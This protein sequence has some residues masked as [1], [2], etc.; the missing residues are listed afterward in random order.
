[1]NKNF[2]LYAILGILIF[3]ILIFTIFPQVLYNLKGSFIEDNP[4]NKCLAPEGYTQESWEEHMSH[5]PSMYEECFSE[6]KVNLIPIN[7][8]ENLMNSENVFL[9]NAHIPYQG[10]LSNTD[11]FAEDWENMVTYVNELPSDK[12][13]PI[14]IYCRSGRMAQISA[15]QLI[16]M[17]YENVYN[18][19]G[20]MKAWETSGR[21]LIFK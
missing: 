7:E 6:S 16:E 17:G 9:I 18:L 14:L 20:G 1:M 5:H 12:S 10:E 13:T 2:I 4:A 8:F 11:L 15:E 3:A 19:D 21:G